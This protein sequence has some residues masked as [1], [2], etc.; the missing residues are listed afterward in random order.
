[1]EVQELYIYPNNLKQKAG[2]WLWNLSDLAVIVISAIIDILLLTQFGFLPPLVITA[3]Y[4][5]LCIQLD[6][7]S[8]KDFISYAANY[9]L[10]KPQ[11]YMWEVEADAY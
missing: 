1:M 7:V 3:V 8:V 5:F 4:A 11:I 10:L 9:F 2:M 6:G